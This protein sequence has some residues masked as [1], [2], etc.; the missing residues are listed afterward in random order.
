M[1]HERDIYSNTGNKLRNENERIRISELSGRNKQLIMCFQNN[2][3][4]KGSGPK[5]I[6]KLSYQIR[7]ICIILGKNLD[8]TVK[9]DIELVVSNINQ[10][11]DIS[12]ATKCDY[13]RALK[14]FYRYFKDEDPRLH[15]EDRTVRN[16]AN[17]LY[18]FVCEG[19][20]STYRQHQIDVSTTLFDEDIQKVVECCDNI[21]DMAFIKFLHETGLRTG[22]MLRL[23]RR[24]IVINK[25]LGVAYVDGKTGKRAV[26]FSKS[27]SYVVRWLEVHPNQDGDAYVWVTLA[28][29]LKHKPLGYRGAVKLVERCFKNAGVIKR[30]NLHWFRH[31]R[32]TLNAPHWTEVVMCKYFGWVLGSK[33]VRTYCHISPKQ[34]EDAFLKMNGLNKED[35]EIKNQPVVCGCGTV[36]DSFS[37]YCFNCGN[38]LSV[39]FALQDQELKDTELA[40]TAKDMMDFFRNPENIKAF[41]EFKACTNNTLK[42]K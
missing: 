18:R 27:M 4:A 6:A 30:H 41:M 19:L 42:Q 35:E 9:S 3:S 14:Q 1:K 26:Q 29:N 32:A 28:H 40:Q 12:E 11:D 36:N 15:N 22:E 5:R 17:K 38:P 25:N 16:E 7:K 13:R 21:R 24:H 10:Q 31:S 39:T 2:L 33:Q 23:Q 34:I 37:R 8:D 20:T